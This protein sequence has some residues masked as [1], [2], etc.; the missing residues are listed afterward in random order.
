MAEQNKL[1]YCV[2]AAFL[3]AIIVYF[4]FSKSNCNM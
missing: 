3:A 2:G 4:I 1:A